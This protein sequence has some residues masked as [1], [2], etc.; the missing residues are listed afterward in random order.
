MDK[1]NVVLDAITTDGNLDKVV[2]AMPK[3][4]INVPINIIT[5]FL[6]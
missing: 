4:I 1:I 6:N 2:K 5:I 3:P